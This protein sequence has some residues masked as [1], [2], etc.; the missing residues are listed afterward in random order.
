MPRW[1]ERRAR[2][3]RFRSTA[4]FSLLELILVIIV[5]MILFAVAAWRLL[6]LRGDA[7][8]THVATVVGSLRSALG[9]AMADRVLRGELD[10]L[11]AFDNSN[12]IDLLLEPPD[13][14]LGAIRRDRIGAV[15]RGSWYFLED[16]ALLGYRVRFPRY[17]ADTPSDPVH[18]YWRVV[19]EFETRAPEGNAADTPR[20]RPVGLRLVAQQPHPWH[21]P[22]GVEVLR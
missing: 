2:S 17:L 19:M 5:V 1:A 13:R 3:R 9:M 10:T 11:P 15:P 12:P 21:Q 7:E 6:P 18:L 22:W 14:Y 8:A 16:A 4:G 20:K